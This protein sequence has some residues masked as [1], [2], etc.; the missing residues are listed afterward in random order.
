MANLEAVACYKTI[1]KIIGRYGGIAGVNMTLPN[2]KPTMYTWIWVVINLTY[3]ITALYTVV[4]YDS[5]IAWLCGTDFGITL[6]V[7]H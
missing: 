2:Y 7:Y 4:F 1:F 6:Q 5:D 3:V